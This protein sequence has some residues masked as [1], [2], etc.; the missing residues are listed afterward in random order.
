MFAHH[1]AVL[2]EVSQFC[3]RYGVGFVRIDGHTAAK[4]RH[5]LVNEFQNSSSCRVAVLGIT[6]AG[7]N[8]CMSVYW[9]FRVKVADVWCGVSW[10]K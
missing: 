7:N 9:R 4:T 6:A 8:C 2:D 5:E 1:K 10:W 3:S